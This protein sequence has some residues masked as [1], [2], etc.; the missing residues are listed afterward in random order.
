[1]TTTTVG[2]AIGAAETRR[3]AQRRTALW[4][5]TPG[6]LWMTLFLVLPILMMVY[7]SFWTQ[8]TFTIEPTLTV[9]SWVT[10]FS[11]DT[12]LTA[13][14]T[15]VR[16]WLTVLVAT[17]VVGYPTA[18]FVGLFVRN[19]TLQ[20]ALLVLCVIPFWTSFLIRVL[21]WRPMLGKEGAINLI[22]QGLGLVDQ[23]IEALL[24]SEL[25]VVIG[26]TQIYCVFMVGPIAFMLG[27]I[28][29]NVIEAARDLGAGFGRIFRTIILPMSMPGVVVGAIFVS[30]MVL[31]EFATS[32]ALSGRKVNLLGNIIVT[33][34]GSLKW[35]FAA[36][37]GVVLTIVM[38]AVVA[39]L[40][41]VVDLRKEL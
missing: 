27:R 40:L 22:L 16:I 15:T 8:T 7:V 3:R 6:V 10:F 34:V 5:I 24:F 35:A 23:P 31:G 30:V 12:Y 13:L 21:A 28:D 32:A 17:L 33:Q 20:T 19:K 18:L 25:S 29:P 26:M 14:W 37:V 38:G 39:G 1:M 9:K 36:V 4:L 11:S 2:E 41:R